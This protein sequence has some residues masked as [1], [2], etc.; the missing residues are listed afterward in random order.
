MGGV[1]GSSGE[2]GIKTTPDAPQLP[3]QNPTS[4]GSKG[5]K[6]KSVSARAPAVSFGAIKGWQYL[7]SPERMGFLA[8]GNDHLAKRAAAGKVVIEKCIGESFGT[9]AI[10]LTL[11][12]STED[13]LNVSLPLGTMFLN[14]DAN[15]S[16]LVVSVGHDIFLQPGETR[17]LNV[18]AYCG[19]S[20]FGSPEAQGTKGLVCLAMR[21][22]ETHIGSQVTCWTW[23]DKYV[24]EDPRGV[25]AASADVDLL[26]SLFPD[27]NFDSYTGPPRD[28]VERV[29]QEDA[30]YAA[31]QAR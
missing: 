5:E 24:P 11:R 23:T 13:V 28:R 21:V 30:A 27:T 7:T 4:E 10:K 20:N 12:N 31:E 6:K 22:P 9:G 19:I 15:L 29:K 26:E 3:T 16:N 1:C 25:E 8:V 18:D 17:L 14:R 2:Q